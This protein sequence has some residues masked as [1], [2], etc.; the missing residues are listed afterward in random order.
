MPIWRLCRYRNCSDYYRSEPACKFGFVLTRCNGRRHDGAAKLWLLLLLLLLA[1][2]VV[3]RHGHL[4]HI[5]QGVCATQWQA[6]SARRERVYS[7][8]ARAGADRLTGARQSRHEHRGGVVCG[9]RLTPS[10]TYWTRSTSHAPLNACTTH[11]CR[12]NATQHH[13]PHSYT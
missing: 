6:M 10:D 9:A 7:V 2:V 5:Q 11:I 12:R 13:F 1:V 3:W 8:R 4:Q